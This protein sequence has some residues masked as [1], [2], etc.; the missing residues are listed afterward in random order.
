MKFHDFFHVLLLKRYVHDVD[1]VTDWFVLQL[2]LE[3]YFYLE[4]QCILQRKQL[5]LWN[6]V[7]EKVKV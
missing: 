3:G 1:H 5:M 4:T 6:R 2:E 7:V